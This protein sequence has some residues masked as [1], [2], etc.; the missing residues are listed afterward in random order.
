L[1]LAIKIENKYQERA[2]LYALSECKNIEYRWRG[3][4]KP[5]DFVS[6]ERDPGNANYLCLIG[7]VIWYSEIV[8]DHEDNEDRYGV[9]SFEDFFRFPFRLMVED[10]NKNDKAKTESCT[11]TDRVGK[12]ESRLDNL[13]KKLSER[14]SRFE[15]GEL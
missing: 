3:G 4:Q 12:I 13:C 7:G 9:V 5:L 6:Y 2:V 15:K 10:K 1:N 11:L 8:P 14:C